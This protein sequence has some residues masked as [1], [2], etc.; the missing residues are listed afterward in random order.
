[1]NAPTSIPDPY[2]SNEAWTLIWSS[3]NQWRGSALEEFARAET[4]ISEALE[5]LA[6]VT[7]RGSVIKFPH[8]VGQRYAELAKATSDGGAFAAEGQ[9]VAK[10]LPEWNDHLS[11]RNMLC[12]GTA[13]VTVDHHGRWHV[14]LRLLTFRANVA[15][16]EIMVIDQNEAE[17][18]L[19]SVRA[20]R[21]RLEA[22]VRQM[23][24]VIGR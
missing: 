20:A 9:K 12:H 11:I 21:Q 4:I 17:D 19:K 10:A 14:I 24:A 3:A 15:V 13:T 16:R 8:L 18:R 1:M 7:G 5:K 2:S 6:T 23:M 22:H